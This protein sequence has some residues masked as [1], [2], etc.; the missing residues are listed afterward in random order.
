MQDLVVDRLT[1]TGRQLLK[2]LEYEDTLCYTGLS[3]RYR[4]DDE[5]GVYRA[6]DLLDADGNVLDPDASYTVAM[7]SNMDLGQALYT[8]REGTGIHACDALKS[9]LDRCGTVAPEQ[10]TV[11]GAVEER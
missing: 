10:V 2:A 7:L 8:S 1:M 4:W 11:N 9:H 3:V 5:R 6:S